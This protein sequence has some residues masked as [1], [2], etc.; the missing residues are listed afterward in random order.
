M[1]VWDPGCCNFSLWNKF[2]LSKPADVG[3]L[4]VLSC[5]STARTE[6][7][8]WRV[9]PN[10]SVEEGSLKASRRSAIY[11]GPHFLIFGRKCAPLAH[12]V[13]T[14]HGYLK[15]SQTLL[16]I[17]FVLCKIFD[18]Q[19]PPLNSLGPQEHQKSMCMSL[20]EGSNRLQITSFRVASQSRWILWIMN[21]APLFGERHAP[22][23]WI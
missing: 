17:L 20:I 10:S 23:L 4:M 3:F 15:L 7:N 16:I 19:I 5:W 1:A 2:C 21:N 18:L 6:K 8:R 9:E 14:N 22:K 12:K 13:N 11:Y